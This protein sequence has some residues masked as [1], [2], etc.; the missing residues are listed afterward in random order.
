MKLAATKLKTVPAKFHGQD[1]LV[2]G[3]TV[4]VAEQILQL[5]MD[6]AKRGGFENEQI[7]YIKHLHLIVLKHCVKSA[8]PDNPDDYVEMTEEEYD[9]LP[10]EDFKEIQTLAEICMDL[11]KDGN[12]FIKD[13]E[14]KNDVKVSNSKKK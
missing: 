3:P 13:E 12:V 9:K 4:A 6:A 8:D 7:R 11:D 2:H 10:G 5:Q 1:V 14:N